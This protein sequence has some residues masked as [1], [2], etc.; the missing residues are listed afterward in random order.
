MRLWCCTVETEGE[1]AMKS[2]RERLS[3]IPLTDQEKKWISDE[4]K[5][6]YL[7][8]RGEDIGIIEQQQLLDLFVEQLGPLLYDKGL[9]DARKWYQRQMENLESDY[10]LLYKGNGLR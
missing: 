10:Y 9:D 3:K 4:I 2:R 5:A 7:D 6:F 8:K 1:G